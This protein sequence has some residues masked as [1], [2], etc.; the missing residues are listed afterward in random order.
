MD[1][2]EYIQNILDEQGR[3]QVWLADKLEIHDKTFSGKLKRNSITAE[4]LLK[5]AII[6]NIDLE[7]LKESLN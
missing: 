1:I 6:L 5:I 7:K 4:E 2:G 3:S